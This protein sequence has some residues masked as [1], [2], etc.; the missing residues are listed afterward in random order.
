MKVATVM[1]ADPSYNYDTDINGTVEEIKKYFIGQRF[2]FG[3][4]KYDY[5]L[6]IETEVDDMQEC[7][8]CTV[9]G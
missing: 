3:C 1:F 8:D 2:N 6:D 5:A 7:I 9:G 4:I